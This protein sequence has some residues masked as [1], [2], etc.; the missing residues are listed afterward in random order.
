MTEVYEIDPI[1][2]LRWNRLVKRHPQSSVFHTSQWL[3]ALH[4]T[5]SFKPIAFSTTPPGKELQDGIAFCEIS[6]WLTGNR[7]IS[8][9]FSDHCEPLVDGSADFKVIL[10]SVSRKLRDTNSL[11]A[12][13]RP[14]NGIHLDYSFAR[15]TVSYRLHRLDLRPDLDTLF[16]NCHRS[17]TQRKVLRA[18]REQLSYDEGRSDPLLGAFY[19]LLVQTRQRHGMPPQPEKWFRNLIDHFGEALKLRVAFRSTTAVAGILT[20]QHKNTLVYKYGCSDSNFHNLGA[21]QFL[22]WRAIMDAKR[23]GLQV[24]DL[25]RSDIDNQGLITFKDRWGSQQSTLT[26][27]RVPA[28]GKAGAPVA[29]SRTNWRWNIPRAIISHLPDR[30]VRAIGRLF[31]R[32]VG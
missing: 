1:D 25:G 15:S 24:F 11:Y 30:A 9:P 20:L 13:I 4:R 27:T 21:V 32:H 22:F 31:Y 19:R 18:E 12:E 2:D 8:L 29:F 5:Y 6:S 17:S 7:L 26:Y 3:E 16:H 23:Q 10:S 14:L 28:A